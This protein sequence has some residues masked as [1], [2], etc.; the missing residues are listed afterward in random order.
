MKGA[1]TDEF[2]A[3]VQQEIAAEVGRLLQSGAVPVDGVI[4]RLNNQVSRAEGGGL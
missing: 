2:V 3:A 4:E 1:T